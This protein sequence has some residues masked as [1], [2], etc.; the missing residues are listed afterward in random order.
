MYKKKITS[1]EARCLSQSLH[2]YHIKN[3]YKIRALW[4]IADTTALY[5]LRYNITMRLIL[6]KKCEII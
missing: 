5:Q 1:V 2:P 3:I 4:S 6:P